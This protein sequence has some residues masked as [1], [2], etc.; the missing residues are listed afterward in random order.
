[1]GLITIKSVDVATGLEITGLNVY[2]TPPPPDGFAN[3]FTP[4][5]FNLTDG[6]AYQIY[7]NNYIAPDGDTYLFNRWSTQQPGAGGNPLPIT[8][9]SNAAYTVY[10]DVTLVEDPDPNPDPDPTPGGGGILSS[11]YAKIAL[12]LVGLA[13]VVGIASKGGGKRK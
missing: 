6:V 1:M 4:L 7:A 9:V 5:Q 8:P 2:V 3:G 13:V 12:G 10:Y 11:V